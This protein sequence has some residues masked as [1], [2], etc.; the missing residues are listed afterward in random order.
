[1]NTRAP[2]GSEW[3]DVVEVLHR[4]Q[5]VMTARLQYPEGHPSIRRAVVAAAEGLGRVLDGI[6]EL[7]LALDDDE[8]VVCERPMPDL[9]ETMS[10]LVE[11][12]QRHEIECIVFV[13]GVD[14]AECELLGHALTLPAQ[15]PGRVRELAQAGLVHILLR[16]A[17]VKTT[18]RAHAEE[19]HAATFRPQVQQVLDHV[20]NAFT[21]E[22]LVE[23]SAIRALARRIVSAC[24]GRAYTLLSRCWVPGADDQA[25]HA[26]N[27]AMMTASLAL[28][29]GVP[30]EIVVEITAAALLHDVGTLL[31]PTA[32]RG[33]PEPI[34][35][36]AQRGVFRHHPITGAWALLAT[37][38]PPL[39]VSVALEHHRGI[40]GGGYPMLERPDPPHE[41]VRTVSLASF[42]DRKRTLLDGR[43]DDPDEA[44]RQASRLERSYFGP[45]L[46]TRFLRTFGLYPPGTIVE[47]SDRQAALVTHASPHDPLRPRVKLLTGPSAGLQVDLE[48]RDSTE[49][50]HQLSIAR[51][52][53]AP[54]A[55]RDPDEQRGEPEPEPEPPVPARP[56]PRPS[57]P[58]PAMTEAA[59]IARLGGEH[60]VPALARVDLGGL[61]IDHR[62]GFVLTFVD[63][64][65]PLE[66]ILD[67]TGLPRLEVLT[68]VDE[69]VRAGVLRLQ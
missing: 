30:D 7:V 67:A 2:R 32:I 66:T 63:G 35:P 3:T 20:L 42:F 31:S 21:M 23:A 18:D 68:I 36:E 17:E 53:L 12:L 11:A 64:I 19:V 8:L 59:L 45:P 5:N 37:G 51:A 52:I 13:R 25:A 47:L 28:A 29:G 9:G 60:V 24:A 27:V 16:F 41:L 69:L 55:R 50:R 22:Q 6:N 10:T 44:I 43:V 34:L 56:P 39:W 54:L 4:V 14:A 62:H 15:A 33:M 26:T 61:V 48:E 58:P 40:D 1:M 49:G 57:Q 38:C 46:V 65:T